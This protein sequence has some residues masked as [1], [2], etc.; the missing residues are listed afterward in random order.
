[1]IKTARIPWVRSA[2]CALAQHRRCGGAGH[3]GSRVKVQGRELACLELGK[4]RKPLPPIPPAQPSLFQD[5]PLRCCCIREIKGSPPP[6]DTI[7]GIEQDGGAARFY[8]S[9]A[10]S[11]RVTSTPP[12]CRDRG[13]C[14][15]APM[16]GPDQ[17]LFLFPPFLHIFTNMYLICTKTAMHAF[18][19][20]VM[21]HET[22]RP[23]HLGGRNKG[24]H[25]RE[26]HEEAGHGA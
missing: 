20:L 7:T 16:M 4:C 2:G 26:Q 12:P 3:L 19:L 10:A 5:A 21:S 15:L 13:R 22:N 6:A 9:C 1:V 14:R 23:R 25:E 8:N 17:S 24:A 18:V 11:R